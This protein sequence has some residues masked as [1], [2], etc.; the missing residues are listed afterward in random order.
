MPS[1]KALLTGPEIGNIIVFFKIL[2][3]P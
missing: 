2:Q 3:N 1:R